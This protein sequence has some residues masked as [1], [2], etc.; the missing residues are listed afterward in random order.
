MG[1]AQRME[2][3]SQLFKDVPYLKRMGA[4]L[5]AE[6]YN[7]NSE[8]IVRYR[9]L[10]KEKKSLKKPE[11]AK[12]LIFDIETAPLK[13]FVWSR[14]KQN[15]YLDQTISEWFMISWAAKWLGKDKVYSNILTPKEILREDDKRI[16]KS[17]WELI[18]QADIVIAHNGKRFDVPKLNARFILNDCQP[19]SPYKQIDTLQIAKWGF[20]FSSN[21]LDALAGYFN[22]KHKDKTDFELWVN[23][24]KGDQEALDYM[25]E[26][27]RN[28]ILILEEVY[29]KLRPW[30]RSHPNLNVYSNKDAYE[31]TFCNSTNLEEGSYYY[32]NRNKF[33]THR[34][35]DCGGLS[36]EVSTTSKTKGLVPV[37]Q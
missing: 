29:L 24:L 25:L 31:C 3:I 16:T 15:I 33:K 9:K 13:A 1:E 35:N 11:G 23:C 10:L 8:D 21:K 2:V 22:I 5:I 36:R 28:D 12:I 26:Y 18:D 30:A 20:A 32:T 19:P 17:I 27:N 7:L 6:R 34:C 14:W 37:I 4:K